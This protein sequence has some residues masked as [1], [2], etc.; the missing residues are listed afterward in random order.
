MRWLRFIAVAT[1]CFVITSHGASVPTAQSLTEDRVI[2]EVMVLGSVTGANDLLAELNRL[3]QG[4]VDDPSDYGGIGNNFTKAT[5]HILHYRGSAVSTLAMVIPLLPGSADAP[6]T[7]AGRVASRLKSE[8]TNYLLNSAYWNWEHATTSGSP[9][10]VPA[11]PRVPVTW[12]H[13]FR[14]GPHWEKMHALWAYAHYTGDWATIGANWSFIQARYQEGEFG[15]GAS[16]RAQMTSQGIGVYRNAA[17][18]FANGLIAYVRMAQRLGRTTEAAAARPYA[19]AAL[20]EVLNR[21]NVSWAACPVTVG[22]DNQPSTASGEWSPGYNLTPE[23]G[24]WI[25]D[26][27]RA[28][29]QSRLTEAANAGPIRRN[30][31][32]GFVGNLDKGRPPF[33]DED[34]WGAPDLSHQLF[35]GR[36]WMLLE[37]GS[38][39][40]PVKPWHVV[41]GRTPEYR[42]MLYLRSLYALISRHAVVS[43]VPST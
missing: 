20:G 6:S 9:Y 18:D 24:R 7:L 38:A 19:R 37:T 12:N 10:L 22:W 13:R 23:L 40:R 33:D 11:N 30:W 35:L 16:Q 42:D 1:G 34:Y 27:A 4:L 28:T 36:A 5:P 43:W 31:W 25:N 26:R 3:A 29:A 8:V 41:G 32:A 39:L 2:D 21:L 14:S 17:N 15:L